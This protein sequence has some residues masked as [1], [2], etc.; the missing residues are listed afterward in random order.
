M[1]P[2]YIETSSMKL[3]AL[4][5]DC[6]YTFSQD[7]SPKVKVSGVALEF[8]CNDVTVQCGC[9]EHNNGKRYWFILLGF[10][11][12]STIVSYS[13][14]NPVIYIYIYKLLTFYRQQF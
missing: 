14:P 13:M 12:I 4:S 2:M 3:P 5:A 11:G 8:L 1:G 10:Y 7:I 6:L 9:L